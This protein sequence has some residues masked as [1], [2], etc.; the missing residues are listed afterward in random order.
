MLQK[1]SSQYIRTEV[2]D[3]NIFTILA[4]IDS[5]MNLVTFIIKIKI[6]KK[7]LPYQSL[8]ITFRRGWNSLHYRAFKTNI[9]G[10][11]G[12]TYIQ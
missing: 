2:V 3:V 8:I 1:R 5:Y 12:F 6:K 11:I 7:G 10:E 4:F 9:I